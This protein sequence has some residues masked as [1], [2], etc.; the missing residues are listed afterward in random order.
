[1]CHTIT[2]GDLSYPDP[3]DR[4]FNRVISD[5]SVV[6][7]ENIFTISDSI[8]KG[9]PVETE[10]LK[11]VCLSTTEITEITRL[12]KRSSGYEYLNAPP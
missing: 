7:R 10:I 6:Q 5:I 4:S 8:E 3:E 12:Q 1:M 11:M 9:S 2:K